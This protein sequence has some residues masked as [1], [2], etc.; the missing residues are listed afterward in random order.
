MRTALLR[1]AWVQ[2]WQVFDNTSQAAATQDGGLAFVFWASKGRHLAL[3]HLALCRLMTLSA[4]SCLAS[5]AP[6]LLHP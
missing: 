2:S 3:V 5:C 4:E 1:L 6:L